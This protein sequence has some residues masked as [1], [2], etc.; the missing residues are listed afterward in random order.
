GAAGPA[1]VTLRRP[2]G[3]NPRA[4]G[5]RPLTSAARGRSPL[6]A[7]PLRAADVAGAAVGAGAFVVT[8]LA[9]A[10]ESARP[11]VRILGSVQV[12]LPSAAR[13]LGLWLAADPVRTVR[14]AASALYRTARRR[15][16]AGAAACVHAPGEP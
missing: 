1:T 9:G 15:P 7:E 8:S 6:V 10:R 16:A 14:R 3:R 2:A 5:R 13:Q 12:G 11:P 4:V